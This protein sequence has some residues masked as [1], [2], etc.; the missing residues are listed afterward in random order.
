MAHEEPSEVEGFLLTIIRWAGTRPDIRGLAL[1]G[2]RAARR[3]TEAS[4]LDLVLLTEEPAL[5]LA[6]EDWIKQLGAALIA[7][8]SWGAITERRLLLRS[9]LQVEVGVGMPSWADSDP[10]DPGTRQVVQDGFRILY[11][12]DSLFRILAAACE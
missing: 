8:R 12:P 7:T 10:I 2:S 11:D 5:Y 3:A 9:G 1:V 6:D 4:D